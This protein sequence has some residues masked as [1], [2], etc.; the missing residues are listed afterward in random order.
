LRYAF[1]V[2]TSGTVGNFNGSTAAASYAQIQAILEAS[3]VQVLRGDDLDAEVETVLPWDSTVRIGANAEMTVIV[4]ARD[5]AGG[6]GLAAKRLS[7]APAFNADEAS[8][9]T[10]VNAAAASQ[11]S[12]ALESAASSNT[13]RTLSLVGASASILNVYG[14]SDALVSDVEIE[15][16]SQLLQVVAS[17]AETVEVT[18]ENL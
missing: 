15:I 16:R 18:G 8:N 6:V 5:Q 17:V 14:T 13:A 4:T 11:L 7:I 10:V 3:S 12:R 2:D 9:A 1:F